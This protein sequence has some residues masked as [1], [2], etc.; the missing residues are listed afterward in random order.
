MGAL[1]CC[2][3]D[4]E[5]VV[6]RI[7]F[8]AVALAFLLTQLSSSLYIPAE[9]HLVVAFG[10]SSQ[11]VML[12]LSWFFLGYA[13]GQMFWGTISD[14]IGRRVALLSALFI[15]GLVSAG[16]LFFNN[17]IIFCISYGAIGFCA[18]AYTSVG[19]ALI[20]DYYGD[21]T[22]QMIS[23]IGIVM[24]LGPCFGPLAGGHLVHYFHWHSV[25]ICLGFIAMVALVLIYLLVPETLGGGHKHKGPLDYP[26]ALRYIVSQSR[27]LYFI[28]ILGLAFGCLMSL[29]DTIPFIYQQHLHVS[30]LYF[31]W[32]FSLSALSYCFG[33]IVTSLLTRSKSS[34][35]IIA[36][37]NGIT[38]LGSVGLLISL[39]G[40]WH[41]MIIMPIAIFFFLLGLGMVVPACKGGAMISVNQYNGTASSMMKLTQTLVCFLMISLGSFLY[42]HVSLL[43]FFAMLVMASVLMCLLELGLF[44]F[45]KRASV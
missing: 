18:A 32:Y 19:N 8:F 1:L 22:R 30:T 28:A 43:V 31:S 13:L 5:F 40:H 27:F 16:L 34:M 4:R 6:G 17:F 21:K 36:W 9:P 15:Y 45:V 35:R 7:G 24:A 29:L 3:N 23:Y 11:A 42:A 25:F 10:V 33:A 12:T 41:P 20:K 38:V 39:L 14:S 37:G 44:L 26:K 2:L